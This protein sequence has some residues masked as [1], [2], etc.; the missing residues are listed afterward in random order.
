MCWEL[1]SRGIDGDGRGRGAA[2]VV[3]GV[4][5]ARFELS[6]TSERTGVP[7]RVATTTRKTRRLDDSTTTHAGVPSF[8]RQ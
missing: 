5:L 7:L 4:I 8:V 6:K 2:V 1:Y 3:V